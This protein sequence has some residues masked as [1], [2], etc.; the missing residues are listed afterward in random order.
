MRL[1]W[2]PWL[3]RFLGF[4]LGSLFSPTLYLW[5]YIVKP[6][7]DFEKAVTGLMPMLSQ[8]QHFIHLTQHQPEMV[9]FGMVPQLTALLLVGFGYMVFI[10]WL[11][12]FIGD[13]LAT[14]TSR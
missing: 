1:V 2:T 12:G 11:G 7:F 6:Y 14:M 13:R 9:L 3:G 4:T 10:S 8:V 5:P